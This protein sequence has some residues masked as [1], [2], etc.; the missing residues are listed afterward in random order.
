MGLIVPQTVK[1]KISNRT[2][3]HYRE[4]GYEFKKFGDI[5][6]VDVFDLPKGSTAKVK[7]ICDVCGK[8]KEICYGD[9][10]KNNEENKLII[11]GSDFCIN[12]KIEDTCTKKYGK[13]I[14]NVFQVEEVKEKIKNTNL[15]RYSCE[16]PMQN[17]E[18]RNKEIQTLREKY[19][20]GIINISQVKEIQD[21]IKDTNLERY[22]CEN[23]MQNEEIKNK[24]KATNLERHGVEYPMQSKEIL[25]KSKETHLKHYGCER[26]SQSKKIRGKIK[27]KC[28]EHY[29]CENPSQSEKVKDKKKETTMKHYGVE[30]CSQSEE[31]KNKTKNTNLR[32]YGCEYPM[33]SS[34]IREKAINSFVKNGT[35]HTSKQELELFELLK[36]MYPNVKHF[37]ICNPFVFDILVEID[38]IKIDVEYDGKYWHQDKRRDVIRDKVIQ[39][40]GFKTLRISAI[41]TL[42]TKQQILEAINIL[43]NTDKRYIH[44]DL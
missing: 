32:K 39:K 44:I 22:G 25:N 20:E 36:T 27:N 30:Y 16:N 9:V 10:V 8:E 13:G 40:Q 2:C 23:A 34:L 21:K 24:V 43:V 11:C 3:K 28:L 4:K 37:Y 26:P 33:Q 41:N 31:I 7:I 35:I 18:I 1:V 17:E 38:N 15:E 12:K 29:G 19:G 14:I 5:I 6:E 42:P